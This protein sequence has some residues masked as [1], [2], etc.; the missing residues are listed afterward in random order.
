MTFLKYMLKVIENKPFL[1]LKEM[2]RF[3]NYFLL[4]KFDYYYYYYFIKLN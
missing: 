4:M 3:L 2:Y 1:V